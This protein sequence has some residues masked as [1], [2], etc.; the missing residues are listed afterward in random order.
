MTQQ[1]KSRINHAVSA[2]V[3]TLEGRRLLAAATVAVE[4]TPMSGVGAVL[5][6]T[7]GNQ[8]T[9]VV[10]YNGGLGIAAWADDSSGNADIWARMF[11]STG[12]WIADAF[13]VNTTTTGA[14]TSP[15]VAVA[16]NG[17]FTVV[18][19]DTSVTHNA[20]KARQYDNTGTASSG[21]L[22]ASTD[23]SNDKTSPHIGMAGDG[24]FVV[25]WDSNGQD[26][27][28]FG[29]YGQ[30]YSSAGST[31]GGEFIVNTTTA[32][33][34]SANQVAM[35]DDG[36]FTVAFVSDDTGGTGVFFQ[37]FETAGATAG[38]ETG[39]NAT[40]T[41]AQ[42]SP[43][44]AMEGTGE[45]TIAWTSAGQDGA[46]NGVYF[47]KF[48]AAGA[49][50]VAEAQGNTTTTGDQDLSSV[51]MADDGSFVV[52]FVDAS[53]GTPRAVARRF[54]STGTAIS[55]ESVIVANVDASTQP[56][57]AIVNSTRFVAT[58]VTHNTDDDVAVT[59][60]KSTLHATANSAGST[61]T[62]AAGGGNVTITADGNPTV[63]DETDVDGLL[64]TGSA[65]ADTIT[66]GSALPGSL[67]ELTVNG[68]AGNDT[69]TGGD[70][71]ESINGGD[72]NDSITSGA[73]ND[74]IS[75]GD[76]ND[77]IDAGADD[78]RVDP[79]TG[80]D[81]ADGGTGT[82]TWTYQSRNDNLTVRIDGQ[83][84]GASGETDASTNFEN[85]VG[86]DGNDLIVGNAGNNIL[87]GAAGDD[88]LDGG[89]GDDQYFGD[90]GSD[91]VSYESHAT[92]VTINLNNGSGGAS[93]ETD[94]YATLE[95]AT[96]GSGNDTIISAGNDNVINGGA[97]IDTVSY[98]GR[99]NPLTIAL[100]GTATSGES[101]ETDTLGTDL[102][103]VIGGTG[104][105]SILGNSSANNLY[106]GAGND[107]I[108][109]MDGNDVLT[110][111]TGNDVFFGG[112]GNDAIYGND[113]NDTV[114]G[115][116][117]ADV[118]Y[119]QA[120]LDDIFGGAGRDRIF[121]GDGDD[122][123]KGGSGNDTMDGGAGADK[124]YGDTGNDSMAGADG[125]DYMLGGSGTDSMNGG[126]GT[127]KIF[128]EN[129]SDTMNGGAGADRI[130]GGLSSDVVDADELDKLFNVESII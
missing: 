78:D 46:G 86:G 58:T 77:T 108:Q 106:G 72:G 69:I 93:G 88:T 16:N 19:N 130:D 55:T 24:K 22:T 38:S 91:T 70:G 37:R 50:D 96:G 107:T 122:R 13:R 79:G 7:T 63:I 15:D 123:I 110:G 61:I 118:I 8:T 114:D 71:A 80:D 4:L 14:Q 31:Q 11:D 95:N 104:A 47:Q 54:D 103:N 32:G 10:A 83:N 75:A 5:D 66:L 100:D 56:G 105:D 21:E 124:M 17:S 29:V 28:G 45:F 84:S 51:T 40:T 60:L 33:D 101:G 9:P 116:N 121:A 127:D 102:E 99:A 82:D 20:I 1:K 57:I 87:G 30:R 36:S 112:L 59:L 120:G 3:E 125:D 81:D 109:G 65:V 43:D 119:G 73:G 129:G 62:V 44:I 94:T 117:G 111:S 85:A 113:G 34:Q 48:T 23:A 42:G 52:S 98:A 128:G 35:A 126:N 25:T 89:L 92:A 2:V 53:T 12:I 115:G 6:N 49:V 26:G 90:D 67:L 39:A 97:G 41:G 74:S 64:I 27:G 68:L 18:W 76:G